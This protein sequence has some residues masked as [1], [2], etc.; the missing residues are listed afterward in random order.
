MPVKAVKAVVAYCTCLS[1]KYLIKNGNSHCKYVWRTN[2]RNQRSLL[3]LR[4]LF[5]EVLLQPSRCLD[6]VRDSAARA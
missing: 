3:L 4:S 2:G 1:S 6:L 5:F